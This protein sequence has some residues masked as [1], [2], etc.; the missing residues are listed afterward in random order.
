MEPSLVTRAVFAEHA[1]NRQAALDL[2]YKAMSAR[3]D[4]W[5]SRA[6]ATTYFKKRLPW[7][8]WDPR[9]LDLFAVRHP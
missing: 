5:G 6:E 4:I 8:I 7:K 3:R 9:T 2:M 1:Q